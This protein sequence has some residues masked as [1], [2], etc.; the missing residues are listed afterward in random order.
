MPKLA[1]PEVK[2]AVIFAVLAYTPFAVVKLPPITLPLAVTLP[3]VIMLPV[4][5]A[6]EL[7]IN[8]SLEII[9]MLLVPV[10]LKSISELGCITML[11][12]PFTTA[13]VLEAPVPI[14]VNVPP[15]G[16]ANVTPFASDE[17][18]EPFKSIVLPDT[19]KSFQRSVG[20]PKSYVKFALGNISPATVNPVRVPTDVMFGCAF[21]V[22]V[23]AVL[24]VLA[25]LALSAYVALATVPETL[26]PATALAVVAKFAKLTVPTILLAL[27]LNASHL[28][29]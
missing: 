12:L 11:L 2:L 19:Y 5:F 3:A 14:T 25:T 13:A 17:I 20:L 4:T 1:L 18:V 22:T 27:T 6:L 26:A 10:T 9:T 28:L 21:V 29:H 24:A 7:T 15:A 8:P 23:P 16:L